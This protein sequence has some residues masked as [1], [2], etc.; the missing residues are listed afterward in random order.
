GLGPGPSLVGDLDALAAQRVDGPAGRLA[1]LFVAVILEG[2][3]P[4]GVLGRLKFGDVVEQSLSLRHGGASYHT[5]RSQ[6]MVERKGRLEVGAGPPARALPLRQLGQL[7]SKRRS[8]HPQGDPAVGD[9]VA[10]LA[11][12]GAEIEVVLRLTPS[13][14]PEQELVTA[15]DRRL[16]AVAEV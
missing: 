13:P 7:P 16:A 5:A 3:E 12:I 15:D 14:G 4:S 11:R 9:A 8:Q 1:N 10:E 2:L 6:T